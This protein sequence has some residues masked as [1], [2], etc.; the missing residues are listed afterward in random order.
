VCDGKMKRELVSELEKIVKEYRVCEKDMSTTD[1][2]DINKKN[3]PLFKILLAKT[4][5]EERQHE[6]K[7]LV[8][9]LAYILSVSPMTLKRYLGKVCSSAGIYDR[10]KTR[11]GS[12]VQYKK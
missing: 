11:M 12:F 1:E 8:F 3:E 4:I 10:V 5:N 2:I 6:E 9:S 7:D